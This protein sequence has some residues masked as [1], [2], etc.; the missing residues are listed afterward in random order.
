[1]TLQE[2]IKA[3]DAKFQQ[4]NVP[5]DKGLPLLQKM[6]WEVADRYGITGPAVLGMYFDMKSAE[7]KKQQRSGYNEKDN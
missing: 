5:F 3:L 4:L 7:I 6:V 2:E 1:M